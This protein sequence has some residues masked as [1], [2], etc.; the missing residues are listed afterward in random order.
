LLIEKN[1]VSYEMVNSVQLLQE[2]KVFIRMASGGDLKRLGW[3][4]NA[5]SIVFLR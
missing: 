5:N 3:N 2:I 4:G 1:K